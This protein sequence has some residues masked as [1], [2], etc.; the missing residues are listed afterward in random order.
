MTAAWKRQAER[1]EERTAL[2]ELAR[3]DPRGRV[4]LICG[5][6]GEWQPSDGGRTIYQHYQRAHGRTE[7]RL[8]GSFEWTEKSD[9]RV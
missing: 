2:D 6:C 8:V 1:A 4:V 9:A 5:R 3:A 7:A